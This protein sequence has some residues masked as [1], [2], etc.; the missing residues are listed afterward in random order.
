ML[1]IEKI[2]YF[3]NEQKGKSYPVPLDEIKDLWKKTVIK[4]FCNIVDLSEYIF[5]DKKTFNVHIRYNKV[6]F[7]DNNNVDRASLGHHMKYSKRPPVMDLNNYFRHNPGIIN[8]DDNGN[9]VLNRDAVCD[10]RVRSK[11]DKYNDDDL[12]EYLLDIKTDTT[13]TNVYGFS[14]YIQDFRTQPRH[15][16]DDI[17]SYSSING[18]HKFYLCDVSE[19]SLDVDVYISKKENVWKVPPLSDPGG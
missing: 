14:R 11:L 3:Y 1:G 5:D 10:D 4:H 7:N 19:I 2:K 8:L 13:T 9:V 16:K 15:V 12:I 17:V 18:K 6:K